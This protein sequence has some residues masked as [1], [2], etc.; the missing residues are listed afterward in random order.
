M[1]NQEQKYDI[2]GDKIIRQKDLSELDK[3]KMRL[4]RKNDTDNL[5]D[6]FNLF[7]QRFETEIN[8]PDWSNFVIL[9]KMLKNK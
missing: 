1:I 9:V 6:S 2:K 7:L 3:L 8:L 5:M 4:N